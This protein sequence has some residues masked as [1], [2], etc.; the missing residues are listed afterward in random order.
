MAQMDQVSSHLILKL[1][2]Q[3]GE[4]RFEFFQTHTIRITKM[5]CEARKQAARISAD[6]ISQRC[7]CWKLGGAGAFCQWQIPH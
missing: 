7:S 4:L 5:R 1:V 3:L 2:R 6:L